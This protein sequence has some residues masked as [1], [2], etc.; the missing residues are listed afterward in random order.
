MTQKNREKLLYSDN[1]ILETA[2]KEVEHIPVAALRNKIRTEIRQHPNFVLIGETGSGKTTCLPLLLLELRNEMG[3]K[4][5]VGVTQPRRI[6][7]KSVSARDS[8]MLKCEIGKKVGY[9]IRFEDVT[10]EET[11]IT[12]MTDG[13]L[14][15]KIQFDPYLL[16]YSII[17]I[18]EA[19]ERSLNIDLCLGL[20][21]DVN[22]RRYELGIEPIRIV[23]SSATIE[24]NKFA[25]YISCGDGDNSV[26][27]QGKMYPVQ[28]MYEQETPWDYDY[29]KA[30]ANKVRDIIN[31]KNPGDILIFM[32]GK[33]EINATISQITSLINAETVDIMALHAE[34]APD[35]QDKIFLPSNKR[36]IIVATN[37]AETSVTIDGI[38]H[39]IDSGLIKQTQFDPKTGI[40]QLC[41]VE[42]ALSG[43]DQRMGR[44]GRTAPGFCYRLFTKESLSHRPHYQV[45]EIQRSGLAQVVL[46]MKKVGIADVQEFDFIDPPNEDSVRQAE[47]LLFLLGAIDECGEITPDGETMVDLSLEPRLGRMV[48]EAMKPNSNCLNEICIIASFLDGKN[49]FVRPTDFLEARRADQLHE[50]FR[51]DKDSDFMVILNVWQ[52]Y[53]RSGYDDEWAKA[54]FL[55]EKALEEA[56]N[57]RSELIE[58]LAS[59]GIFIDPRSKPRINK[60]AIG[61]AVAAGLVGNLMRFTGKSLKKLDGTKSDIGIHP[62]SVFFGSSFKEGSLLVSDEIFTNPEGRTYASNC[63][64]V[65]IEWIS[66]IAPQLSRFNRVNNHRRAGG[67]HEKNRLR[68]NIY[69]SSAR[70]KGR[71]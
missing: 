26:A 27:I 39:V 19:H 70:F 34:L 16:E 11:D 63:L 17:M 58:V 49:V 33:K 23:V 7:T 46:A 60:E 41:L 8:D 37:I 13:I 31:S 1:S 71:R 21:K 52:A 45:P 54:N 3:L 5:R 9:H 43:L 69:D 4:G 10:S 25:S 62:S 55:N 51:T 50:Q 65:K 36:K 44:A 66:E 12:F 42:H 28:V 32:P 38:K 59:H 2:L 29:T 64:Q 57:V 15:R 14:L 22:V 61:K 40:E 68:K 18:D 67:R 53:V 56:K 30:A 48:I 35:E 6:A 47:E 20:L 24:R